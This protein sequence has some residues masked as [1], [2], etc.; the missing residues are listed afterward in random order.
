MHEAVS[1]GDL[2][3]RIGLHAELVDGFPVGVVLCVVVYEFVKFLWCHG[4]KVVFGC[5]HSVDTVCGFRFFVVP[6]LMKSV[7]VFWY[8]L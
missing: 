5:S 2:C 3:V 8:S 7:K 4:E 6:L 1:R